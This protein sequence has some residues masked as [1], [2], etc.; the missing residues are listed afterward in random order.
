MSTIPASLLV[1]VL[2]NVLNAG[3]NSLDMNGLMLTL[4]DRVPV[5]QVL[6]FPND[7]TSVSSYFGPSATEVT[8]ADVYFNG[9]DNST[10]KPETILFTRFTSAAAAAY[11]RGGPFNSLTIPQVKAIT[12]SLSV[13]MDGLTY[14]AASIDLAAATSYSA[15]AALIETGL[16]TALPAASSFTGAIAAGVAS[17][18]GDIAGNVLTVSAVGS[19]ALVVGALITGTGVTAGTQ[20]TGQL[21]GTTGGVGTY[22]VNLYQAVDVGT[23]IGATYGTLTVSA[24]ASGTLSPGQILAGGTVDAGTQITAYGTGE[25]LTGTYIV[26]LTQT[27]TS[28]SLTSTGPSLDASYD[29]VSGG[30]I[31]KSGWWGAGSTVAFPT[32]TLAEPV[33]LTEATGAVLSQGADATTPATFMTS[34]T[35]LTQNWAT[36][37]TITDPDADNGNDQKLAFA[38]W[39]N[40]ADNRYAYI[41]MDTDVT[42]RLSAAATTSFGYLIAQAGYS[43]TAAISAV[44]FTQRYDAFICGAAASINFEALNGRITFAFKG[45][46]G[47][48]PDVTTATAATNLTANGY[49]FYGVYATA[50]DQFRLFQTGVVSGDFQWLDSYINQIWLNNALQLAL[51]NLLANINSVP[52]NAFG[53]EL[54]TQ[55]CIDPI[56][57]A[58]NFGSIRIGV[59]LSASQEAQ[60]NSAAGVDVSE[61]MYEQGWYL[62]VLDAAPIVRQARQSPPMNLWFMDGQSIQQ[63]RLSS[64]LVQ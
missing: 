38:A 39:T 64:V 10:R 56:N 29:S 30:L 34:V 5:G 59:P 24:V 22:A 61:T 47:L 36:F 3:G 53:Y 12:G 26:N 44:D 52:Y 32:G 16:N 8:V 18:T 27:E 28:G 41:A 48:V 43:G 49:N 42:A 20:I 15:A 58:V 7:G 6:A 14:S 4:N 1:S 45:Q 51:L 21:S 37:M 46:S 9:F 62:Q 63:I 55:A 23:T 25:G 19:G 11:V 31:I 2:P 57:A 17:V 54:L 33:F 60:I 35:D 50:N 13:I 40:T